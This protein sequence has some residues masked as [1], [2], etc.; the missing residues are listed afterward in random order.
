MWVEVGQ[1]YS[2]GRLNKRPAQQ[3]FDSPNSKNNLA[4][5]IIFLTC[6]REVPDWNAGRYLRAR[7]KLSMIFSV[8]TRLSEPNFVQFTKN[9]GHITSVDSLMWMMS[10]EVH[11]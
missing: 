9:H 10:R 7:T 3:L 4:Q 5:A 1:P 8:S 2:E 6:S 11:G